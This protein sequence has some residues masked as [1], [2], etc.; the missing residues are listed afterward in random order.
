[1]LMDHPLILMVVYRL[2]VISERDFKTALDQ[3]I[4]D[5]DEIIVLYSGLT[6]LIYNLNFNISKTSE[7]QKKFL[8]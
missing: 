5:E 2:N 6:S 8:I 4:K 7:I 3:V 1:M